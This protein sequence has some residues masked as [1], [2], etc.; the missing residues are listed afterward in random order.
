MRRLFAF[1]PAARAALRAALRPAGGCVVLVT[2]GRTEVYSAAPRAR[3][4]SAVLAAAGLPCPPAETPC[5]PSAGQGAPFAPAGGAFPFCFYEGAAAE[6]HLFALAA[7]LRSMLAGEDEILGQVRAA[8]EE[9]RAAKDAA[10][11]GAP[12]QAAIACG[13]RVRAE[14]AISSLACSVATLA[15]AEVAAFGAERVF[16]IGA[17]GKIGGAV[18]KNLLSA[19][20]LVT[21]TARSHDFSAQ[22]EGVLSVPYAERY[23]C[24]RQAD[25][26]VCCTA[27]PHLVLGLDGLKAAFADGKPRLL[28]DLAVPPD[29]DPRAGGLAGVRLIDIDGFRAAAAENN[30]KKREAAVR[31]AALAEECLLDYRAG[32]ACR[33]LADRLAAHPDRE[34]LYRLRKCDPAAFLRAAEEYFK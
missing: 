9:S 24:L 21:A 7:G 30:Q 18:L 29:I 2:C 14:T 6:E 19:G 28:I 23:A 32:E 3:L 15:A 31:A 25:C 4:E 20:V 33:R 1:A 11:L 10:G 22:A 12:F 16:M 27:S 34:A 13:K 17:T 26:V 5:A 8:Y